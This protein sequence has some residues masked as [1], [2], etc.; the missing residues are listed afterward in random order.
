[1][2]AVIAETLA[3][4]WG[5]YLKNIASALSIGNYL[6]GLNSKYLTQRLSTAKAGNPS[7]EAINCN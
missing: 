1:M 2:Q 3:H 6:V 4:L 5:E 7:V